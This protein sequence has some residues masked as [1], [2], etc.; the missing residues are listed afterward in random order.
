MKKKIAF[1]IAVTF[2][3]Q[4]YI[5]PLDENSKKENYNSLKNYI[6]KKNIPIDVEQSLFL[7]KK[8]DFNNVA[9]FKTANY[10]KKDLTKFSIPDVYLF[11]KKAILIDD[12][13]LG[14]CIIDRPFNEGSDY[15]SDI[16][17][18]N[19]VLKVE[20]DS[21]ECSLKMLKNSLCDYKGNAVYPFKEDKAYLI[22]LWAK[23]KTSRNS[24][25]HY[26]A[27]TLETIHKSKE[28]VNIFFLN[29]DEYSYQ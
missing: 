16:L 25:N 28:E 2:L 10:Y 13:A 29:A 22:F 1:L 8:S 7:K 14:G 15:Y 23:N 26:I 17:K 11:N 9:I 4:S 19:K 20:N 12:N 18:E 3:T 24:L 6:E 5:I 21:S 27:Y